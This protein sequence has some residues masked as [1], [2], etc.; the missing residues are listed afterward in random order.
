M[1]LPMNVGQLEYALQ[2]AGIDPEAYWIGE[3]RDE[4]ACIMQAE[5][6]MW[7][8]FVGQRGQKTISAGGTTKGTL[9]C[10]SSACSGQT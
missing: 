8:T 1:M 10:S 2:Q 3:F 5:D 7:E 4:Y 6:G 9:A